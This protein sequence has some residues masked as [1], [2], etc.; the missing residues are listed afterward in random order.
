MMEDQPKKRERNTKA[1]A[2]KLYDQVDGIESQTV[3]NQAARTMVACS[4][5]IINIMRFES[6]QVRFGSG[7][8]VETPALKAVLIGNQES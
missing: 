7:S 8:G 1:L 4:N 3:T 6:D 2:D 5:G